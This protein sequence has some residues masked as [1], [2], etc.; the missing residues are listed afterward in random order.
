[1]MIRSVMLRSSQRFRST[2]PG[3]VNPDRLR[4]DGDELLFLQSSAVLMEKPRK[5]N[6]GRYRD[7]TYDPTRVKGV[8]SR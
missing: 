1:M 7:R 3:P 5:I 8:L 4:G 2:Q 6:G